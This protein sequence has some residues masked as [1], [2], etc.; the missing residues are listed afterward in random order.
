MG[1]GGELISL[2]HVVKASDSGY[3][4]SFESHFT[5]TCTSISFEERT[6]SRSVMKTESFPS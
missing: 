4:E 5:F 2:A 1:E 6:G 3:C